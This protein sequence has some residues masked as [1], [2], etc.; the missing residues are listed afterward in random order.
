MEIQYLK[1]VGPKIAKYLSS[2]GINTVKDALFY[3]P[4]DYEDRTNIK[5]ISKLEND[6]MASVIVEV[7]QI[8]PSKKTKTGKTLNKILFK[9][10][11]GFIS[12]IWFNQP[13]I[14]NNF[15]IGEKVLL[16]GKVSKQFGE[17]TLVDPQYEKDYEETQGI[18]PI[19]SINKNLTQKI[20]RK[21]IK[22]ALNF[23]DQEVEE[24]LPESLRKIYDL[25]DIKNAIINIHFPK[26]KNMLKLAK[27]RLKFE[28]LL[29]IQLGLFEL[30]KKYSSSTTSYSMAVSKE[31]KA[32]K[33]KLPF[34]LTEAQRKVIREILIDMKKNTPMNRLLQGDVGSGKTIISVIALFNCA[35]N[36]Y[37]G[38]LMAP[39]EILAEQHY[40]TILELLKD[41]NINIA[42]LVGSTSKKQK[43][44][45][46]RKISQGEISIVIGTHALLQE[47]VEFK[48]LALVITDEQHRFG[49]RQRATLINKG[50]NPHVLVMTATPIPRTLALFMYGDMDISVIDQLPP[51]R[52]KVETYFVRPNMREKVYDFVKKEVEKGRQAYVICPLVEESEKLEAE[53][54]LEMAENL[55]NNFLKYNKIGILHGKMSASEKDEIMKKFKNNEIQ[56]LVSTTVVEVGVNVPNA[57]IIV[58]ENADRF[59][60]AQLHQLRGR[61]GRGNYKS[62]CILVADAKT[63]DA[64]ERMKIMTKTN[65][66]FEIAEKDLELRGTGEFFGTRQH[67]LPELKVAN[68][69]KDIDILMQTKEVARELI[70]SRRLLDKDYYKL[71]L[72]IEELIQNIGDNISIN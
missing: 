71:K 64:I 51:G 55:K 17:I 38:V 70:Q 15:K 18:N 1:G 48:N 54:V 23:I 12:G 63:D 16:Y 42:L 58:I 47:N 56:V 30:K 57:T 35:M 8:F 20:M 36:G 19:Y 45:I 21:I 7:A 66:G 33:E 29:I 41:W 9:N 4:R 13:Y 68:L 67:G 27:R 72:R 39:T 22:Q 40:N 53:S 32:L 46:I 5:P 62:Y 59:G 31:L 28:E 52:Q 34:E 11:T 10:E 6:E 37:Q 61:V 43:E 14:K 44:E 60:L 65:S 2:L 24:L 50:Y 49:V 69:F 26:D 25:L 3:F